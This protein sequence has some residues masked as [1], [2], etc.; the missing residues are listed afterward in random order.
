M[1]VAIPS[2]VVTVLLSDLPLGWP[3]GEVLLALR[4]L[5]GVLP[6]A[7]LCSLGFREGALPSP[8]QLPLRVR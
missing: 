4:L 5:L 1:R 7:W 8:R 6:L 3:Y 2:L